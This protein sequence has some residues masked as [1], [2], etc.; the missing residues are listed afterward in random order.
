VALLVLLALGAWAFV[1]AR[2]HRT[3]AFGLA[4]LLISPLTAYAVMPLADVAAEH[5]A[6]IPVLGLAIL[7]AWGL[8]LRSRYTYA[9]LAT[10]TVVLGI[11]TFQRNKIWADN[12]T[13]WTDTA[14]K[15]PG[16]ARPHLNLGLAYQSEGQLEPALAEYQQA[17]AINPKLAPAYIN[18]SDIYFARGDVNKCEAVLKKAI[19]LSPNLVAP[20]INLAIIALRQNRPADALGLLDKAASVDDSHIVHFNRG[21]ALF[22]LGRYPEAVH[23]YER[24]VELKPDL[25]EMKEQ[26]DLRLQRLKDIGVIR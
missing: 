22:Q 3:V 19:E 11:I 26:I 18:M 1:A 24:A 2:R 14:G 7:A 5:R 17:L 6:Y 16:L 23:E 9:A 15:S 13:L 25:R 20:Y 21:E 8:S 12:L 10:I 4:A